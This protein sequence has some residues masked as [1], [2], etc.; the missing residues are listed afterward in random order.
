M[1][2][3]SLGTKILKMRHEI[4]TTKIM[5]SWMQFV[6]GRAWVVLVESKKGIVTERANGTAP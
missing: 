2:L 4:I 5:L 6:E 1:I 3:M